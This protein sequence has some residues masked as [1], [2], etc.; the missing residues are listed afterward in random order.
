MT[1]FSSVKRDVLS[2]FSV[3]LHGLKLESAVVGRVSSP[4]VQVQEQAGWPTV[5][6]T[7]RKLSGRTDKVTYKAPFPSSTYSILVYLKIH[8]QLLLLWLWVLGQLLFLVLQELWNTA[9]LYEGRGG[10]AASPT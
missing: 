6:E 7:D 10:G 8:L 5:R 4:R 9:A 3:R 2:F 1:S